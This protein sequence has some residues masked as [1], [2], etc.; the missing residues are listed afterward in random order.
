[1]S[2]N[3]SQVD[4]SDG[5]ENQ[6]TIEHRPWT[7]ESLLQELYVEQKLPA[8]KISD[9]LGCGKKTIYRWMDKFGIETRDCYNEDT[10]DKLDDRER[11][12]DLYVE[13]KLST[14]EIA[15]K[16][17]VGQSTV[18]R[19]L[20]KNDIERRNIGG[21]ADAPWRDKEKLYRLYAE[22]KLSTHEIAN[23]LGA[24]GGCTIVKWLREYGIAVRSQSEAQMRDRVSKDFLKQA[25]LNDERSIEDIANEIDVPTTHVRTSLIYHGIERRE[26]C[27]V[28]ARSGEDNHR[29]SGGYVGGY[30][31]NW[32]EQRVKALER[33]S[34]TCQRC[35][36]KNKEHVQKYNGEI[37]V[38]HITPKEEFRDKTGQLNAEEANDLENLI[39]LCCKCHA[40]L[41][42]LPIDIGK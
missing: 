23:R 25:Y 33:D 10:I 40:T 26:K 12:Y 37:H 30:G 36:M 28:V 5:V 24:S 14:I 22:K 13:Q 20:D 35:G 19:K 27:H 29:W 21:C 42:G 41:E 7:D 17:D 34:Y 9:R 4:G 8:T 39:S 3:N 6:H 32:K 11:L 15:D 38:H 1:M 31:Y 16:F 2:K 18:H